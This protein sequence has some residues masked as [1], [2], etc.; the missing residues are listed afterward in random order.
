MS[1]DENKDFT[2][3]VQAL[4]GIITQ[5]RRHDIVAEAEMNTAQK[6]VDEDH[7]V[8]RSAPPCTEYVQGC[9]SA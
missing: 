5:Q 7:A 2:K 8:I 3:R 6:E 4:E 1:A 9:L